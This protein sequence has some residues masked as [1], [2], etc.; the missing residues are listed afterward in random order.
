MENKPKVSIIIPAY[1]VENYIHRGMESCINQTYSN[2]EIVVVDDGSYDKTADIIDC[3]SKK[4]NRIILLRQKNRGVSNARNNALSHITGKYVMFLDSDDW[5]ELNAVEMLVRNT[6][7]YKEAFTICSR[8]IVNENDLTERINDDIRKTTEIIQN[9][10]VLE[11][12]LYK[13]F[14]FQSSCYKLFNVDL[15][16]SNEIFFREDISHGEDG[17]FVFTYLQHISKVVS[18]P[19]PLWNILDRSD[20]ASNSSFNSKK[21][22]AIDAAEA[23]L[24]FEISKKVHDEIVKYLVTR[25]ETMFL[26]ACKDS[27]RNNE[28]EISIIRRKLKIYKEYLSL[29]NVSLKEKIRYIFFVLMPLFFI[30]FVF[31]L[32]NN[33]KY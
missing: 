6:K 10:K 23:M 20:S 12:F 16:R 7:K 28:E 18:I 5:L 27:T 31:Q 32:K 29:Q 22:T 15:I 8:Y 24:S 30:A 33:R 21:L 26:E 19:M 25:A 17:L 13:Y 4:D 14:Y 9:R 1:N 3:Y 11:S 2:I